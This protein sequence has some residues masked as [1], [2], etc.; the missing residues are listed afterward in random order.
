MDHPTE[1]GVPVTREGAVGALKLTMMVLAAAIFWQ[2][3]LTVNAEF[4]RRGLVTAPPFLKGAARLL[5]GAE[6]AAPFQERLA[7]FL[8]T[9]HRLVVLILMMVGAIAL[10]A[11]YVAL[12][13]LFDFLYL[14]SEA[15]ERR[16][17]T[18]FLVNIMLILAH[19]GVVY[20]VVFLGRGSSASE[21]PVALLGLLVLNLCW[22]VGILLSIR[23]VEREALRGVWYL[24]G[25]ALVAA[26][27]LFCA[28]WAIETVP[29]G[30]PEMRGSQLVALSAGVALALCLADGYLQNRIYCTSRY[31]RA[32]A[33]AEG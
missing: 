1:R 32:P 10:V 29:V 15:R 30:N 26:V 2:S 3:A 8:A 5:A 24:A 6:T 18:G 28:A 7:T 12:G 11:R 4:H 19:A 31:N 13:R 27:G 25:T 33:V 22:F 20:A 14:E 16:H 9:N 21:V 23:R 17:Y